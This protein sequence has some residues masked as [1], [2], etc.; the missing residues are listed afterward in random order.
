MW[1]VLIKGVFLHWKKKQASKH[2]LEMNPLTATNKANFLLAFFF[3]S[4]EFFTEK[5]FS[6][7]SGSM[8]ISVT[9]AIIGI[10]HI[11][12]KERKGKNSLDLPDEKPFFLLLQMANVKKSPEFKWKHDEHL[13]RA[14]RHN[15]VIKKMFQITRKLAEYAHT[16]TSS[17]QS[18][19]KNRE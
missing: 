5:V 6:L 8:E 18:D 17:T 13:G 19:E 4:K 3:I 10:I 2:V 11:V 15:V 12:M 16:I 14:E 9:R 1:D 7:F